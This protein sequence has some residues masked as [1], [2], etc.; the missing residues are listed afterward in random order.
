MKGRLVIA[1]GRSNSLGH[2]RFGLVVSRK[3]GNS[4]VRNRVKRWFREIVRCADRSPPV[5]VVL[6]ARA[7][8]SEAGFTALRA[9]VMVA[10]GRLTRETTP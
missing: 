3:V 4:V 10:L 8:A 2:S 5:D 7:P 1:I 9:D 6:I